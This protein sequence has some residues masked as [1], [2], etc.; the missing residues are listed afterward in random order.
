MYREGFNGTHWLGNVTI[1][2][3]GDS[4]YEYLLKSHI[5]SAG[6]DAA[7]LQLYGHSE[8]SLVAL[9]GLAVDHVVQSRCPSME[10]GFHSSFLSPCIKRMASAE[11][12]LAVCL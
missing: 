8:R 11:S 5:Q 1:G 3:H 4:F 6:R 7:A 12:M 9:V 10:G 2:A